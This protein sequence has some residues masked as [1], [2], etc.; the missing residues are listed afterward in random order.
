MDWKIFGPYVVPLLVAAILLRRAMR[1]QKPRAVRMQRLWIFPAILVVATFLSLK[2]EPPPGIG[3]MAAFLFAC[4]AGGALGWFRVHTLE[5]MVDSE[6]GAVSTRATRLGALLI[7]GL[8]ALRYGA[9]LAFKDLGL[10]AGAN[11]VHVTDAML[12][13]STS[14]F[15]ARSI[16]TWIRA[17]ALRGAPPQQAIPNSS[18]SPM[19]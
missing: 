5:F 8:I 15:V 18:S 7:V 12:I 14:M 6:S 4:L 16:H 9:D 3:V 13:F 17:R 10:T 2:R 11:V 1:A 19:K